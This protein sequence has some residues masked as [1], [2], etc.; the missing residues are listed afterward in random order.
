[1]NIFKLRKMLDDGEKAEKTIRGAID[2]MSDIT[3]TAAFRVGE[4]SEI[5]AIL[6]EMRTFIESIEIG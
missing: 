2:G 1:M 3:C 4:L 5:E 6:N